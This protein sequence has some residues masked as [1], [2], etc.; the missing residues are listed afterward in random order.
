MAKHAYS[1]HCIVRLIVFHILYQTMI[2]LHFDEI[3]HLGGEKDKFEAETNSMIENLKSTIE[4]RGLDIM[5]LQS[6]TCDLE[7]NLEHA[8]RYF[9]EVRVAICYR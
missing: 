2:N 8:D 1:I 6:E 4:D 3:T 5:Y 7:E 9:A